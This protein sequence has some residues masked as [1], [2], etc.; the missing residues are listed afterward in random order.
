M[1]FR[2]KNIA[3]GVNRPIVP[4]TLRYGNSSPIS[5]SILIDSGADICIFDAQIGQLLGI[6]IYSG[7]KGFVSGITGTREPYFIHEVKLTI[8]GKSIVIKAGFM[9]NPGSD[10]YGIVGQKGFFDQ[11]TVKFDYS[12]KE[13]EIK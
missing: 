13:I 12:K 4:I 11:F 2:Y 5:Y 1:K 10:W 3:P 8:G 7:E 9:F 6:D